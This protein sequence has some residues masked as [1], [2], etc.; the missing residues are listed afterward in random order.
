MT[1]SSGSFVVNGLL[2]EGGVEPAG[3][4]HDTDG[5][6]Q[7]DRRRQV[8]GRARRRQAELQV[9]RLNDA[10]AVMT[11]EGSD[12]G[13]DGQVPVLEADPSTLEDVLLQ[14]IAD[15]GSHAALATA[16][17]AWARRHHDGTR[18]AAVLDQVLLGPAGR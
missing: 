5:P 2:D 18:A 7:G 17:P 15:R 14:V 1:L 12:V 6:G 10:V 9:A 16:G 13:G 4:V 3:F 11:G 8:S